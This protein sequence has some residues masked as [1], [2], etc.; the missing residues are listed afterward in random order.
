MPAANT[1]K[2]RKKKSLFQTTLNGGITAGDTSLI[3]QSGSGLPTDTAITMVINR[4]NANGVA[5]PSAMEVVTGTLSGS[6]LSNLVR[7]E[8][9]TTAKSHAN[10]S[11]VEMVWDAETWNDGVDHLLV[12]H[13]QDGTHKAAAVATTIVTASAKTTPVN[14]DSFGIVD[15]EA[16]NVLK[17]LTFTNLKA[18]LK[19]YFDT[20]YLALTGGTLTG[21]IT[22]GENTALVLDSALSADGKYCG[23][24]EAGTAGAALAFGD[25]VYF[26][27]SDSRWELVDA[28]L[29]AGY[30]KKLGICVLAAAADGD[31][32]KIMLY[33]KIRAD[34]VF[35][36]F[37]IAA[38]V[39]MSETAGDVVVTQ[40]TTAD[41]A[42]RI[43]GFG[44]T[45]D[46]LYFNPSNDYMVH[47]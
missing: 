31:A 41:V 13:N 28:N 27:A 20:L 38:P 21:D 43:V 3:L 23:I 5:T 40:P 16:S 6:T 44:N 34:A 11:V 1:D 9:A 26:Q 4:V 37:T 32:T 39:Y 24:V 33:G 42:I 8:D 15:S 12:E 35:P 14:A 2:L 17:E 46:E 25:L 22:F 10:A 47:N 36:T 30:D 45:A 19:T 18:F 29:S 7:A